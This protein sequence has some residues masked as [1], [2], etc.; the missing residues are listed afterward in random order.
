MT[1]S[2]LTVF[3]QEVMD[4]SHADSMME[5]DEEAPIQGEESQVKGELQNF[6]QKN[7]PSSSI[8][9]TLSRLYL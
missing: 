7:I 3:I 1:P 8:S 5:V 9:T 2:P 4:K 6:P